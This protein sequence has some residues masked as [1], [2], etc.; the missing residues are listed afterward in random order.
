[1][2]PR[3]EEFYELSNITY[4]SLIEQV[5]AITDEGYG[6]VANS[7]NSILELSEKLDTLETNVKECSDN[8]C[9]E[10][11]Y[12]QAEIYSILVNGTFED[13]SIKIDYVNN[14][15]IES[16]WLIHLNTISFASSYKVLLD[17]II[18]CIN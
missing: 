2:E 17:S 3:N 6:I 12:L 9:A 16:L 10:K 14:D 8:T 5:N 13:I 4:N 1:M 15:L 18:A 7:S 11:L